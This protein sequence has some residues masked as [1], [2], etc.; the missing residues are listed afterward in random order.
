MARRGV[1]VVPLFD[2]L[3][4][5]IAQ[6]PTGCWLF[7]GRLTKTGYAT[8]KQRVP[9]TKNWRAHRLAYELFIGPIPDGLEPDHLCRVTFCIN[10][11][12]L[13]LVTGRVNVLRG[14]APTA[15][16]AAKTACIHGHSFDEA[17]TTNRSDGSRRC[18]A[19]HR[20]SEYRRKHPHHTQE[21]SYGV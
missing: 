20:S 12:H 3:V 1:E 9:R 14:T 6:S 18:R 19:C 4:E 16:N 10:P 13:E 2:R 5:K 7:T 21:H 8:L 17:N 15:I 11:T